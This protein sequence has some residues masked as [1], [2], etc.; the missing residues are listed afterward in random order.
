MKTKGKVR[1]KLRCVIRYLKSCRLFLVYD[2]DI[3]I[4]PIDA[5]GWKQISQ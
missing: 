1:M 2:Y 5:I 3:L 4:A